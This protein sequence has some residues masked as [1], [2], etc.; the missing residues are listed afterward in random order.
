[1]T[2][3]IYAMVKKVVSPALSSVRNLEF[4]RSFGYRRLVQESA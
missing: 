1:L 2:A 3:M 4:L